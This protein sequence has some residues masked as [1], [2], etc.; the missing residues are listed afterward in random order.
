MMFEQ[1][2]TS[3]RIRAMNMVL[4]DVARLF[5]GWD[6][7]AHARAMCA[8]LAPL[9][10]SYK[11]L[12][13]SLEAPTYVSWARVNRSALIRVP[14]TAPG[15]EAHTRLELRCPDPSSNPYLAKAVM[16]QAGLDGIR[17]QLELPEPVEEA[18]FSQER[19]RQVP[20]LPKSL[21]EAVDAL[22]Q[23]DVI[24]KVLDEYISERY[25]TAKEQEVVA[26]NQQV[27]PWEI[28]RYLSRF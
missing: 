21:E 1:G 23:D 14:S 28:T 7:L 4:S 8:V 9:V 26:Y 24:L 27:T 13:T 3:L 6:Q 18:L 16:L 10:N 17:H 2:K 15:K 5:S 25:I 22:R 12:G 19:P 20:V 11:R